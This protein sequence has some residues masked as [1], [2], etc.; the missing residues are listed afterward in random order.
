MIEKFIDWC[1]SNAE[2]IGNI[3]GLVAL[4]M[5]VFIIIVMVFGEVR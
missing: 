4:V 5:I 1:K 3:S 2:I